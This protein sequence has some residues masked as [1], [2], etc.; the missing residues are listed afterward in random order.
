MR[1]DGSQVQ[2]D[3]VQ[4]GAEGGR[5]LRP[6]EG[7]PGYVA[8]VVLAVLVRFRERYTGSADGPEA[9]EPQVVARRSCGS[10]DRAY[11]KRISQ[12]G[13]VYRRPIIR[14]MMATVIKDQGC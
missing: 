14:W 8:S 12:I 1:Q 9:D 10:Q 4:D 6:G 5:L 13:F 3:H 7:R 11:H 2:V